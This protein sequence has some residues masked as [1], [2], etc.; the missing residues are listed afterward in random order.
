MALRH[1][2]SRR[3]CR[4][5]GG[6]VILSAG[7]ATHCVSICS[8]ADQFLKFRPAITA[9]VFKYRHAFKLSRLFRQAKLSLHRNQASTYRELSYSY[10]TQGILEGGSLVRCWRWPDPLGERAEGRQTGRVYRL[11]SAKR[12]C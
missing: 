2:G 1:A 3:K 6:Q 9:R 11:G 10:A 12:S 5:F 4:I 7:W 8:A